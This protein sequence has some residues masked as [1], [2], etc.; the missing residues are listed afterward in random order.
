MGEVLDQGQGVPVQQR[1]AKDL[2]VLVDNKL[3]LHL[4]L[5]LLKAT[6]CKMEQTCKD[7]LRWGWE[8]GLACFRPDK[9]YC[10]STIHIVI[11]ME[12]K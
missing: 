9:L 12:Q 7:P 1:A 8:L 6:E 3:S 2:G 4:P 5:L 10:C 11:S